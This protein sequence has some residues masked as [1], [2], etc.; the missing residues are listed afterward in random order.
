MSRGR[1]PCGLPS[2]LIAETHAERAARDRDT[3]FSTSFGPVYRF[4]QAL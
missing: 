3:S 1:D 2:A 4:P